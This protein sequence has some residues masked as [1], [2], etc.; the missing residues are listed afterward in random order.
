M[1]NFRIERIEFFSDE[2]KKVNNE[3]GKSL[4]RK[5]TINMICDCCNIGL[6]NYLVCRM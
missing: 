6:Y 5:N 1:K 2:M 4:L 3:R